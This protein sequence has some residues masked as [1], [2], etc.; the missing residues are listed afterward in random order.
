MSAIAIGTIPIGGSKRETEMFPF[1]YFRG[2]SLWIMFLVYILYSEKLD[3][4]YVGQTEDLSRR[5]EEHN[6]HVFKYSST[7][8]TDDWHLYFSIDCE[9]R[10]QAVRIESHIK[11]AKSKA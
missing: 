4:Y 11:R 3:Q 10:T 9:S 6:S 2:L 5:I 8:I 7:K 1:L